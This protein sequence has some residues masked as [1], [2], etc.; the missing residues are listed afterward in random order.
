MRRHG[1]REKRIDPANW[2]G[3]KPFGIGEGRPNNYREITKALRE[4]RDQLPYA[5]RILRDGTCDGCALGTVGVRDWTMDEIH[6]CNVRLRLLR[7]NTMP[8]LDPGPLADVS[9]LS[10]CVVPNCGRWAASRIPSYAA[11]ASPVSPASAGTRRWT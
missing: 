2:V 1:Q 10:G 7:L 9:A 4:N 6:L 5:M 3:L 11:A 8:A